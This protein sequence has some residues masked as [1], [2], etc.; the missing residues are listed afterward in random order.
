MS[1]AVAKLRMQKTESIRLPV[2]PSAVE[3]SRG[4]TTA[5]F[6]GIPRLRF[7]SLGMTEK[8]FISNFQSA[9]VHRAG[10]PGRCFPDRCV[11]RCI[12]TRRF[13]RTNSEA[14]RANQYQA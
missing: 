13:A 4:V 2:I 12:A 7:A 8:R 5:F 14:G 6:S 1:D 11:F 9:P 10:F 3:R